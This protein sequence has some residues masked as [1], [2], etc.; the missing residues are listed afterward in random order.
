G[1]VGAEVAPPAVGRLSHR[2]RQ[3]PR[4]GRGD[5]GGAAA[6]SVAGYDMAVVSAL[7]RQMHQR[8]LSDNEMLLLDK[9]T[10]S[11]QVEHLSEMRQMLEDQK[12]RLLRKV[13]DLQQTL[14]EKERR[15]LERA[16]RVKVPE[17]ELEAGPRPPAG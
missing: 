5:V 6:V 3:Q 14:E 2:K 13:K 7:L 9:V 1:K 16:S 8:M 12:K 11:G 17:G 4:A 10:G 15:L